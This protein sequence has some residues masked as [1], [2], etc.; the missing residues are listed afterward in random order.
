VEDCLEAVEGSVGQIRRLAALV[1][2]PLSLSQHFDTEELF[3]KHLY[4][5]NKKLKKFK[6]KASKTTASKNH[7]KNKCK[8]QHKVQIKERAYRPAAEATS[9]TIDNAFNGVNSSN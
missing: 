1:E 3:A 7:C 8:V 2:C 6:Q 4:F 5:G 9:R